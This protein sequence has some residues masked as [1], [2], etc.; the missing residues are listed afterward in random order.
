MSF[1]LAWFTERV[2]GQ[3]GL[4]SYRET[5]SGVGGTTK[6]RHKGSGR[7][8]SVGTV[9]A[10]HAQSLAPHKNQCGARQWW[11]T[12]LIPHSR[13]G[14]AGGR[15]SVSLSSAWSIKRSPGQVPKVHRET[16]SRKPKNKHKNK[17]QINKQKNCGDTCVLIPESR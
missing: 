12:P 10:Q 1:G 13:E 16:L 8:G 11:H 17:N 5:L 7:C 2:P 9:L 6:T 3:P 14:E 4:Q 15:I